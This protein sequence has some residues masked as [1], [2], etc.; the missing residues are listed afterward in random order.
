MFDDN[1]NSKTGLPENSKDL[2]KNDEKKDDVQDSRLDQKE[3]RDIVHDAPADERT[4][5]GENLRDSKK[6]GKVIPFDSAAE[7]NLQTVAV[8]EAMD[9][10]VRNLKTAFQ[11]LKSQFGPLV[12]TLREAAEAIRETTS[13]KSDEGTKDA[14]EQVDRATHE[15]KAE[16]DDISGESSKENEKAEEPAVKISR[17]TTAVIT[18]G[19]QKLKE[20]ASAEK[21]NLG[22]IL[23]DEFAQFAD[24]NLTDADYTVDENGKRIVKLDGAFMQAHGNEMIPALIRGTIGTFFRNILGDELGKAIENASTP[25]ESEKEE[26]ATSDT[27][28][29]EAEPTSASEVTA[30]N[31]AKH[32]DDANSSHKYSVQFDFANTLANMIQNAKIVP[33]SAED[34]TDE[35]TLERSKALVIEGTRLTEDALNGKSVDDATERIDR[36][37]EEV[38]KKFDPNALTPEEIAAKDEKHRKILELSRE[39]E[40]SMSRNISKDAESSDDNETP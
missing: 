14:S 2:Q 20:R 32:E 30:E 37:I 12:S 11:D 15:D 18:Q 13:V 38:D 17:E 4:E 33:N 16:T 6:L 9:D 36:A 35:L 23:S 39:F 5:E 22:H 10:A 31:D 7:V 26:S 27:P 34:Q 19:L 21:L 40:R 29:N 1:D 25:S 8:K 28:E 3:A 24:K